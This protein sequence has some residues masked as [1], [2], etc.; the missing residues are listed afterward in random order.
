MSQNAMELNKVDSLF[1][2]RGLF[3]KK[4]MVKYVKKY[5]VGMRHILIHFPNP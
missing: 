1:L 4:N 5:L 2:P 3:S